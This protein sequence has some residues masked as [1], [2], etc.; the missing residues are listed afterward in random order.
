MGQAYSADMLANLKI[1]LSG[2]IILL[3]AGLAGVILLVT[4]PAAADHRVVEGHWFED[5][6]GAMTLAEVRG[7]PS[8][9]FRDK[10]NP[11]FG[12]GS[13]W[14]R[15]RIDPSHLPAGRVAKDTLILRVLSP[16]SL[17]VQVHDPLGRRESVA[18]GLL[19]NPDVEVAPAS[20]PNF[21]VPRGEASRD[22]W[23]KLSTHH[24]RYAPIE[25]LTVD[26]WVGEAS[27]EAI[28]AALYLTFQ[29][30]MMLW[31]FLW[32]M[33]ERD[34]IL[35]L[36]GL[37][38][39]G[40]LTYAG[41]LLGG[42]R[43]L[44]LLA[45]VPT[46]VDPIVDGGIILSTGL[47]MLCFY[48]LLREYPLSVLLTRA[49]LGSAAL[50]PLLWILS[51]A[52]HPELGLRILVGLGVLV[53]LLG[54][55][56]VVTGRFGESAE[57]PIVEIR[58]LAI[59]CALSLVATGL[60]AIHSY[61]L[62]SGLLATRH[63]VGASGILISLLLLAHV[64]VRNKRTNVLKA[65]A[66]AEQYANRKRVEER[67]SL[68]AML[69]HEIKTPLSTIKVSLARLSAVPPALHRA[70]RD[71]GGIVDR[72]LQ[73]GLLEGAHI[74]LKTEPC[75]LGEVLASVA[76]RL[77]CAERLDWTEAQTCILDVDRGL[78]EVILSNL[79]ENAGKYSPD[80]TP[81]KVSCC[82]RVSGGQ[83]G[84]EIAVSNFPGKAGWP[85]PERLFEKYYRA[86][87]AKNTSGSGL[88]LY[89]A[90]G[91]GQMLSGRVEYRPVEEQVRFVAWLPL[92]P[93]DAPA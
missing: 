49:I 28:R 32:Y 45:S 12:K 33:R 22:V 90:A 77:Q 58:W 26:E 57:A 16:L 6:T 29:A 78:L 66:L 59:Q 42:F 23:L 36:F 71:I 38:L 48:G 8:I 34:R 5:P 14:V 88:G 13:I 54:L 25:V 55:L 56:A 37:Y 74:Q 82:Q 67:D 18:T 10:L 73:L 20:Y 68:L 4:G 62:T 69:A 76:A 17:E 51:L 9:P 70:V 53:P 1:R 86:S 52:G 3:V 83:Q 61:G 87:A 91:I 92:A 27:F 50:T 93:V 46:L 65:N 41:L 47:M 15:L 85:D 2:L 11:G 81:V 19:F 30:A 80:G 63:F 89:V 72:C 35:L 75:E 21:A 79:L 43:W 39:V 84:V 7:M 24:T 40:S 44:S 60:N 31:I 64:Q